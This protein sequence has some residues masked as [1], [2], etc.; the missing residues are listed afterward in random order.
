MIIETYN[1]M[2]YELLDHTGDIGIK[3]WAD[4]VKGIFQEAAK[5]LFGIITDLEKVEAHLE[6]EVIVEGSGHEEL[7]VAWLSE[8]L[9]LHEV[10]ELLFCDFTIL[11]IQGGSIKGV[12]RGERFHEGRHCI[13]TAVK[14]V[15]YHQLEIQERDGRW[16]A[17]I[18]F[19]I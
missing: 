6:R 13:K 2:G 12:A 16:H 7:M 11:E 18:I 9:Y 1:E 5:A 10:E 19:D 4:D 17:Q 3:V 15:T 8:L 14:A